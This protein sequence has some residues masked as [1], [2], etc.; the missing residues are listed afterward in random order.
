MSS[1]APKSV[2]SNLMSSSTWA[3]HM[4]AG[5]WRKSQNGVANIT[6]KAT[7]EILATVANASIDDVRDACAA[8]VA[9]GQ[10]WAAVPAKDRAAIM[11]RARCNRAVCKVDGGHSF[12]ASGGSTEPWCLSRKRTPL[13]GHHSQD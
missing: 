6:D 8:A 4:Y 1:D 13:S 3:G 12:H 2:R 11:R 10:K 5:G 7:D 9:A